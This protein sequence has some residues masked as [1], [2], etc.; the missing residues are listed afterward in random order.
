MAAK[1]FIDGIYNYCDRWCERCT[2][3][4]RCRNYESTSKLSNEELD[5]SNE[6]FW[7]AISD[8][9]KKAAELLQKAAD[10]FGV[11]LTAVSEEETKAYI[12]KDRLTNKKVRQHQLIQYSMQY[13]KLCDAFLSDH[14]LLEQKADELVR[15]FEMGITDEEGVMQKASALNDCREVIEWYLFFISVKLQRALHGKM[16]DDGWEKE[17]G[18]Q[19]DFDGSAKI[20]IIACQRSI[21]AWAG[22][23]GFLP[24]KEDAILPILSLLQ[25]IKQ[26]AE[27]EFPGYET[28]I[29]P[30]FDEGVK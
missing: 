6:K 27:K 23:L 3:T 15:H 17:N 24:E 8:N 25:K 13:T 5:V 9:F 10:K 22:L 1:K 4:T 12:E 14:E 2:F 28:F 11:D 26:M 16:E 29:R 30:G 21:D 20:A 18:F 7:A 19:N